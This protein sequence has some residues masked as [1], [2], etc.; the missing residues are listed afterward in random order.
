MTFEAFLTLVIVGLLTGG[1]AG[2][3]MKDGGYGRLWDV[4]LGLGG[5]GAIS[6]LAVGVGAPAEAGKV[7]MAVVAFVGA[8]LLIV[9]Q[10]KILPALA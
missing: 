4:L 6:T 7:A 10:R 8:S 1:L 3:V 2:P 5:S 9:A